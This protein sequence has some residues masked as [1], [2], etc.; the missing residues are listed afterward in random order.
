MFIHII[1]ARPNFVK[2]AP[3]IKEFLK[4]GIP[5]KIIHTGQHYDSNMSDV[6]LEQ[7]N[8]P[9]P[10][11]NLKTGGLVFSEQIGK[12]IIDLEKIFSKYINILEGVIV[13][14][15]VN[16]TISASMVT[17]KLNIDLIH[18]ESGLRSFDRTMPEEINRI[19]TDK[20]SKH[21]FVTSR[22]A[23]KNLNFEGITE[24]IY[25]CG[26]T[27]IDSLVQNEDSINSSKILSKLKL[28]KK[29][30]TVT[31]LHRP[32][33]VDENQK[34]ISFLENINNLSKK[35]KVVLPV[36][37]RVREQI[38]SF[39]IISNNIIFTDPLPYFDFIKL[40]KHSKAVISDS[41]G[42]QEET[43]FFNVPCLT[44]RE[45]TERPI[46]VIKGTNKLIGNNF[47][48][49]EDEYNKLNLN[50]LSNLELWDGYSSKRI[51]DKIKNIYSYDK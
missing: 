14:G 17:S 12:T 41:G 29:D 15:D 39:N 31:T 10:D 20:L 27:M 5:F 47:D 19:V 7:L 4:E 28:K 25:F 18:I 9:I 34:I 46:T 48:N 44:L 30:Y 32:S 51:L 36:H 3:V 8:I 50:Q 21:L 49:I 35:I 45:N 16:A 22:E 37:P 26:N 2:A 38:L 24:N 1:A 6:F 42:V 43:S 13:Y 40:I 33:N 23:I 11:Y